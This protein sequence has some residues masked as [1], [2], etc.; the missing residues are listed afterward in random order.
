MKYEISKNYFNYILLELIEF[1]N[2]FRLN[3]HVDY[4][5]VKQLDDVIDMIRYYR[6][7]AK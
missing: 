3:P 5:S 1:Q 4:A 2:Q 6:Q 7:F